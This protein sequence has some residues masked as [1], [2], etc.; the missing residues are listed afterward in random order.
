MDPGTVAIF[1]DVALIF[2]LVQVFILILPA[3]FLLS[4]G[5]RVVHRAK[6]TLLPILTSAQKRTERME[7]GV[8]TFS[9]F[10]VGPIIRAISGG[11]FVLEALKALL[12]R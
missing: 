9:F 7:R 2:L 8:H 6:T 4:Y 3:L 10:L 5:L 1:R 11:A 12:R